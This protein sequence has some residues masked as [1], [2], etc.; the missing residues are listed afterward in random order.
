MVEMKTRDVTESGFKITVPE[1]NSFR[2]SEN[3]AYQRLS[4]L[5]LKEMDIGWWDDTKNRLIL[6]ELK[7]IEI[8]KNFDKDK[9]SAH[10]YFV[11]TLEKK[12]TDVLLMLAAVWV[13][14]DSGKD[15]AAHLPS[16]VQ[17]YPGDN[18]INFIFL[19]DTPTSR[20][21][22]LSSVSDAVNKTLAGRIRLF[23]VKRV[24]LI[25]FDIA[26]K[27]GFPIKRKT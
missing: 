15:I 14:T 27:M 18:N 6:L 1:E 21:P 13:K 17:E 12:A 7:G 23:G 5:S 9:D 19:I 22:L 26:Q 3:P 16:L 10:G 8:W 20:R 2:F 25:N 24:T 11:K 4:G